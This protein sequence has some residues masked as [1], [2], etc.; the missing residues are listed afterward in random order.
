[1]QRK[2]HTLLTLVATLV[3]LG[4]CQPRHH[5]EAQATLPEEAQ[6][7]NQEGDCAAKLVL[8]GICRGY[9]LNEDRR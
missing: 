4:A 1:M 8:N 2:T 9:G 5:R 3:V 7:I 6:K